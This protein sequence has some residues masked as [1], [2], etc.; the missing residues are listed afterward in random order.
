MA[1]AERCPICGVSVKV[2]NLR[3]HVDANHPR[4]PDTPA[5]KEKIRQEVRYAP[6]VRPSRAFRLRKVHMAVLAAV[7]LL[8]FGAYVAAP[9]LGPNSSFSIDSCISDASVVYHIHPKLSIII[10]GT[11]S[12]IPYNIG[13]VPGCTKPVHTH[14]S[15]YDPATQPAIIHVESPVVRTFTLGDFFHVWGQ[16]LTLTQV[17]TYAND[18]T[19]VVSMKVGGVSSSAFGNLVLADGQQIVI[20]Y[21][22][23]A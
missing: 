22:P 16:V 23:A 14:D 11:Q 4:H 15:G 1:K 13:N 9:Y 10:H 19:N 6:E 5:L 2:E 12:P 17:L 8:G 3:R 18:G 7:V 21:G 20:S